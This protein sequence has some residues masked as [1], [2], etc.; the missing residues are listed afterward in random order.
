M[1]KYVGA[2]APVSNAQV[3][4]SLDL[5]LPMKNPGAMPEL[6]L[7]LDQQ[8]ASIR[9]V[10]SR[11]HFVH[12][13][14]FLP[15]A[16][17]EALQVLTS[18]DGD[19]DA[20][21]LDF[22][23]AIGT[24]FDTI[25]TY[26]DGW[27]SAA[28]TPSTNPAVPPSVRD[29]PGAFLAFIK[30]NNLGNFGPGSGR[31]NLFS[32]YPDRTVI[33][34]MGASGFTY[35]IVKP[36][37]TPAVV[38][39]GDVQANVLR[40]VKTSGAWHVGLR[41]EPQGSPHA[42]LDDL[43]T[44]A[45]GAPQLSNEA[46]VATPYWLTLGLTFEGLVKLG[47]SES[48]Q[49]A[50][51]MSHAPFARGPEYR[52]KANGDIGDSAPAYWELGG[53]HPVDMVVSIYGDAAAIAPPR[54]ALLARCKV[55]GVSQVNT[56]WETNVLPASS[57]PGRHQVH[58][59]Y[60]DGLAQP[61]MAVVGAEPPSIDMQPLASVGEFLLGTAYQNV[62]GGK[63]SL[64]GLS[65]A[66]AQNATF[67]ALR[68]ME[69]DVAGF[70]ALLDRASADHGVDREWVAA[71]LMGRWRDGTPLSQSPDA[72]LP[73]KG[74]HPKPNAP[75]RNHFDY[76]PS[77]AHPVTADDSGGLRCPVGAHVRR[78]NPR[79]AVVAGAPHSRRVLRRGM[80]YGPAYDPAN[81]PDGKRRGLVGLFLCANLERQY[82]FLLRN[83]AQGDRATAGITGEQDP[84]IGAQGTELDAARTSGPFRIPRLP[85]LGDVVLDVP[86]LVKTVGSVYL[87]MPGLGGVRYLASLAGTAGTAQTAGAAARATPATAATPDPATFD[88]RD[89][90]FRSDPFPTLAALC[91]HSPVALTK[92]HSTWAFSHADVTHVTKCPVDFR[93]L[94][95][96]DRNTTGVLT[97]DP[98]HHQACRDAMQDL[99]DDVLAKV[100]VEAPFKA[101][102]DRCYAQ[103]C[104]NQGKTQALDWV[105]AFA[106]PVAHAVFFEMFGLP[107]D[108]ARL[109]VT[110]M[111]AILEL[112]SP[113]ENKALKAEIDMRRR[114]FAQTVMGLAT[115]CKPGRMFQKVLGMPNAFDPKNGAGAVGLQMERAA[116][117]ATLPLTG[118]MTLQWFITLATWRLLEDQGKGKQTLLQQIKAA[119]T[120]TISNRDVIDELLR[121]DSPV[122]MST[123]H[124]GAAGATLGPLQLQKDDR[125]VV[126]WA[127][128]SRDP[129]AYGPN[130]DV[131]DFQRKAKGPG[132]AFGG[133]AERNC[134]GQALVYQVMDPYI[135]LLRTTDPEPRLEAGFTP[136]WGTPSQSAFFRTMARLM[137][138]C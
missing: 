76:L 87:L 26:I 92:T 19:F 15:T 55:R 81:G 7:Y 48:D 32:A 38:V 80:P 8:R 12:F 18:F 126:S 1:A 133:P 86:R 65:A 9:Q 95:S 120:K 3:S 28:V 70:E 110:Q 88:P 6:L 123:R 83:W 33:D 115:L 66:L 67:A 44:G 93:K 73:E 74:I 50:F 101:T 61:Q 121:F 54:A 118:I 90:G 131:I 25:L 68:V 27:P 36:A 99:F 102:V 10:F 94:D 30:A 37:V 136:H 46:A 105:T 75:D 41:F 77:Q 135:E 69:Q 2:I 108:K 112:A 91:P 138:H 71:K 64:D 5:W 104:K 42:L 47:I 16:Q 130:A 17:H 34:I 31:I 35:P 11:L 122:L 137:V 97:M 43:L 57:V 60:V 56:P 23:Q 117:A 21:V 13:A 79:N 129:A 4:S 119:S 82:E 39:A 116:N 59:G 124:V 14:R 24:Q 40:G 103:R 20:Y 113:M 114:E 127:S 78:M 134:M 100:A 107:V 51:H 128:A 22:V 52:A 132:W 58:F 29:N 125:V 98:P 106:Q 109:L 53:A 62:Y 84:I 89:M 111:E 96:A 72:P 85:G 49:K 63:N 45:N